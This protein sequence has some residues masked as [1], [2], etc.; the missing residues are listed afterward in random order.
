MQGGLG[1]HHFWLRKIHSL[2]G[3]VPIGAFL[4]E[5]LFS[6][7]YALSGEQA[8]NEHVGFL[9]SIPQPFLA[10][11]E[12]GF[13]IG[14]IAFHALLGIYLSMQGSLTARAYPNV[15]NWMYVFQRVT[16]IVAL[17][18]IVVH[19]WQFRLAEAGIVANPEFAKHAFAETAH[20]LSQPMW[21]SF[22]VVG[23]AATLF[24]F[25][26]GISLF[27]YHW[28]LTIGAKSQKLVALLAA[29]LGIFLFIV[30]VVSMMAFL[31]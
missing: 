11:F 7:A 1:K 9:L 12:W 5:H 27:C 4:L 20:V 26:N 28:G 21:F 30:G 8:F 19:L 18:Y 24:H 14:P 6:N 10:V 29:G 23:L 22:Y 25:S 16:G 15:R 2:S 17:I 13:I 3:I 31:K